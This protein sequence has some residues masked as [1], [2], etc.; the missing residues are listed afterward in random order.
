M[1][2]LDVDHRFAGAYRVDDR[3]PRDPVPL[4]ET[5]TTTNATRR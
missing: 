1:F 2:I 4:F 3:E 5:I